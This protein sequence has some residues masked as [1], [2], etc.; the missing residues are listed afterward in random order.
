VAAMSKAGSATI[1]LG[2]SRTPVTDPAARL[3]P[4]SPRIDVVAVLLAQVRDRLPRPREQ[5]D[6]LGLRRVPERSAQQIHVERLGEACVGDGGGQAE[7]GQ[8]IGCHQ[9]FGQPRAEGE[10]RHRRAFAQDAASADL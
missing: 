8:L 5:I 3:E 7:A 4:E 10:Q 1:V 6:E 2:Q 9:A